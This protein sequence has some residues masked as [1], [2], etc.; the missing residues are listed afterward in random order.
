MKHVLKKIFALLLL[1][2]P[3]G[4]HARAEVVSLVEASSSFT[5]AMISG[6]KQRTDTY[7]L[8]IDLRWLSFRDRILAVTGEFNYAKHP[9]Y[10]RA[11]FQQTRIGIQYYP[12]ALGAGFEDT[13]ESMVMK[14]DAFLKPYI[15]G[16]FG[17]GRFFVEAVDSKA[18][19]ELSSDY[20]V[21]GGALGS[22]LQFSKSFSM[23]IALDAGFAMGS[24]AIAFS[25]ILLRPRVGFLMAL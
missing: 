23:D 6:I 1:N 19:A 5:I 9:S 13:F 20:L 15:G 8:A 21:F 22:A 7:P 14:Y 17:M 18:A 10:N 25:A 12:L 16:S 11:A 4:Q 3:A 2:L 24:S